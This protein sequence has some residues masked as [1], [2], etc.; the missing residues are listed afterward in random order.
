MQI[1]RFGGRFVFAMQAQGF[2]GARTGNGTLHRS[3]CPA[4]T[5]YQ[6]SRRLRRAST[7]CANYGV[8]VRSNCS[9]TRCASGTSLASVIALIVVRCSGFS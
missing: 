2:G 7:T 3:I 8:S 5:L 1:A 4:G 6:S 9:G